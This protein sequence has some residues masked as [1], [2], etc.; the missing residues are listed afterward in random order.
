MLPGKT[1]EIRLYASHVEVRDGGR[2][3]EE[4]PCVRLRCALLP[5]LCR[6]PSLDSRDLEKNWWLYPSM[7]GRPCRNL[8]ASLL[9]LLAP[10]YDLLPIPPRW[11]NGMRPGHWLRAR[12]TSTP[13]SKNSSG[14]R[15]GP[16]MTMQGFIFDRS[17]LVSNGRR[18]SDLV[19]YFNQPIAF[20]IISVR[21]KH[22]FLDRVSRYNAP[23]KR[24]I[25]I[26]HTFGGRGSPNYF[27]SRSRIIIR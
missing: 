5:R 13:F 9:R 3:M 11:Q 26:I 2:L 25:A 16:V 10:C 17:D 22:C 24:L 7:D 4:A 6:L 1:V 19:E 27:K 15:P 8:L 14:A 18:I 21:E 20:G 12:T 23:L